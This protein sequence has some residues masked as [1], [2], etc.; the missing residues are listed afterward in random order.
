MKRVWRPYWN[1]AWRID[2]LFDTV[3]SCVHFR[4]A[5]VSIYRSVCLSV[6]VSVSFCLCTFLIAWVHVCVV[7]SVCLCVC[8]FLSVHLSQCLCLL[9][10]VSVSLWYFLFQSVGLY[11]STYVSMLMPMR[12]RGRP[13][14]KFVGLRPTFIIH[15]MMIHVITLLI[16]AKPLHRIS[17]GSCKINLQ[18]LEFEILGHNVGVSN[19]VFE[20]NPSMTSI[21][22]LKP[23]NTSDM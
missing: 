8:L 23:K 19:G 18:E 13:K 12:L 5:S 9:V 17:S 3:I 15:S 1:I 6:C 4:C 14:C 7:V 11:A 20:W 10:Y 21:L 22:L 16:R 2:S